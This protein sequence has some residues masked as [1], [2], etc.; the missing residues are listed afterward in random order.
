MDA[1][2]KTQIEILKW[3]QILNVQPKIG[4]C[5][6]SPHSSVEGVLT[7]LIAKDTLVGTFIK[8]FKCLIPEIHWNW[9]E[10]H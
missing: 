3:I 9:M 6:L 5:P 4:P 10:H 8:G 2:W 7:L 1:R